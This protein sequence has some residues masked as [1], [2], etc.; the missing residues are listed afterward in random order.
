MNFVLFSF[1][2]RLN[3]RFIAGYTTYPNDPGLMGSFD[4][5]DFGV[6]FFGASSR[7]VWLYDLSLLTS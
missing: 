3:I 4:T 6:P 7:K 5:L 1:H 2:F